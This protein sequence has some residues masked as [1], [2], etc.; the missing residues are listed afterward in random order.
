[1]GADFWGV[2]MKFLGKQLNVLVQ[3]AK[4]APASGAP[5]LVSL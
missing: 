4:L 2:L 3:K 5:A 1:M